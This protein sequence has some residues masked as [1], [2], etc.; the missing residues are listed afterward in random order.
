MRPLTLEEVTTAMSGR[1]LGEIAVPTISGVS[2]DSRT[3][4]SGALFF[5][6]VGQK[7]DGHAFVNEVLDRGAAAVVVSD[8]VPVAPPHRETGRVILVNDTTEA[9]GRLAAWYRRQSAATVIAVVGSNGKTTTK[10]LIAAVLGRRR[11]GRAATG[12]FNNN[13]GVPLTLLSVEPSD[14]FVVVEIGTNHPG[15]VAAL[16]RL[17]QPDMGVVTSIG[18]EHLE[19]FGD[20]ETV[21]AEEF[22]LLTTLRG[23]GFVAV[24]EQAAGF[25]SGEG[26]E[27]CPLLVYGFGADAALR[28]TDV[29]FDGHG[30]RFKVNGRFEYYLPAP[31]SHNVGNA[32]A[33]IAIGTRLR[34]EHDEMAEALAGARLPSMRME[35]AQVGSLTIIND[36]YNANPS[37]VR[38]ALEVVN[39]LPTTGR[40]V[41]ILGDMRELG[42]RAM[43]CHQTIGREAG[44]SSAQVIIT[45]GAF[46]RVMADG[47]TGTAGT[48]KRLYW[49]PTVEA[50]AERLGGLVEPGD[51]V[52]L[53]ASRGVRLERLV[54][55]LRQAGL[56]AGDHPTCKPGASGGR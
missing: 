38:A 42:D 15:E 8:L 48:T 50:A 49:F 9:L 54:E 11:R 51:I 37:S 33:A 18:E 21:A 46:A 2:T 19:F 31:G 52:L 30:Q 55:P 32:L 1:L 4:S 25:L 44:R 35:R 27:K 16:G 10:D 13:I 7:L 23:R 24:S 40:K 20:L 34:M 41:L 12:S 6:I 43:A 39:H 14:E 47:A 26:R 17:V 3:L 56:A 45:V 36:A 53:K 28:A 22:S 5:A 29:S